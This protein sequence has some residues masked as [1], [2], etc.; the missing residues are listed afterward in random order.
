MKGKLEG[1]NKYDDVRSMFIK[2]IN[3]IYESLQQLLVYKDYLRTHTTI[4][5]TIGKHG[6]LKISN[7]YRMFSIYQTTTPC[8][9][10]CTKVRL[11]ME[12]LSKYKNLLNVST[13]KIDNHESYLG[14]RVNGNH[15]ESDLSNFSDGK[16]VTVRLQKYLN[17]IKSTYNI[18]SKDSQ[19]AADV[20][21]IK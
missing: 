6:R 17:Y 14:T 15:T 12:I 19:P 7:F 18:G 5:F 4:V 9:G 11:V 13:L 16:D 20:R 2:A 3:K 8:T 1:L 21:S 10:I